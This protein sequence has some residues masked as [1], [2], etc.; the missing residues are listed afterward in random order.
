MSCLLGKRSERRHLLARFLMMNERG[1]W[2]GQQAGESMTPAVMFMTMGLL[3][4]DSS[5]LEDPQHRGRSLVGFNSV[6]LEATGNG[7]DQSPR[8]IQLLLIGR[9][10]EEAL[11]LCQV[12][13][14]PAGPEAIPHALEKM[15]KVSFQLP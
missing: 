1:T 6:L 12:A 9:W 2:G 13:F 3:A 10:S 15:Y 11:H 5:P 7:F 8:L 4:Y 14:N